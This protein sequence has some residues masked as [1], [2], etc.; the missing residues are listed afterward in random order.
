MKLIVGLGNPGKEYEDTR[1][2][3]GFGIIDEIAKKY[4]ISLKQEKHLLSLCGRGKIV[5]ACHGTPL[6]ANND[7]EFVIACPQTFMNNSGNAVVKLLNWFK[8]EISDLIVDDDEVALDIGKIR[9]S[10]GRS[11]AGHHGLE[12]IIQMTGGKQDFTRLR[13]GVGPDPGGDI[14]ADYVL[15]KFTNKENKVIEKVISISIEAIEMLLNKEVDSVMNK[16]N[17]MEIA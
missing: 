12:S 2:N 10:H 9:I 8:L 14:R 3:I 11:A 13:I 17:G 1:H 16:Y 6:Q 4:K 7:F 5:E 15:G